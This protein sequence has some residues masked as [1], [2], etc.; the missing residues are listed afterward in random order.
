MAWLSIAKSYL[1]Y[2]CNANRNCDGGAWNN[3][4]MY[5]IL[6]AFLGRGGFG[7]GANGAGAVEATDVN[8]KLNALSNQMATNQNT[9]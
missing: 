1:G 7:F 8:G 4:F 3:P 5:L 9:N 2:K 6:L